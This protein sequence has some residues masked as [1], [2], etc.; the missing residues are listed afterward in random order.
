MTFKNLRTALVCLG[1]AG[2]IISGCSQSPTTSSD[3]LTIAVIPKGTTHEFWKSVHAGAKAAAQ[4]L[5]VE[6][7]WKGPQREDDREQ[8]IS[9]VDNFISMKVNGIVLAPLDDS[10]LRTPVESA[11]NAG[12]PVVI[13][14]S[15]L[16]SDKYVSFVATDNYKGGQLAG[17]RMAELLSGSGRVVVLRYQEG[18]ASTMNREQGFLDAIK[19]YPDI[20]VVSDNQYGGA[21]TET[22]YRA[23]ENLLAPLK[24]P[25]GKLTIDG[26]FTP[27][28]S[29]TFGMLRALQDAKLAGSVKFIGFDSSEKLVQALEA[30][31]IHGLV[32]QNPYK[33]GYE[34]VRT[35]V[36]Y[37]RGESVEK[38]IDTG[39]TL[40]TKENMAQPEVQQLLKPDLLGTGE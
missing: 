23:S 15:D 10:A 38:K 1:V 7:I 12:I 5:G 31:E 35:L 4:E 33:M 32:L 17:K 16:K 40:V 26:I 19:N 3:K 9:V 34:G 37:I 11:A 39:A 2:A 29:T 36:R 25:G 22:A 27:N 8:Q 21:T 18:S 20:Q 6:I 14:D 30:D 13:F 28:E 24:G